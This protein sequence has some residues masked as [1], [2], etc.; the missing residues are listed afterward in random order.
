MVTYWNSVRKFIEIKKTISYRRI[1]MKITDY[2]FYKTDLFIKFI[3]VEAH[4]WNVIFRDYKIDAD[5]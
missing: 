1:L 5:R 2:K 3:V 4:T